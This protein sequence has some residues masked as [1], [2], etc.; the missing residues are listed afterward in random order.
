[1]VILPS[2]NAEDTKKR[3]NIWVNSKIGE[4]GI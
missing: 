2:D 3:A 1:M 4:I